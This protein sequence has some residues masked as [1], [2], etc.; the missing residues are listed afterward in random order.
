MSRRSGGRP[1]SR[2]VCRS[3]FGL[4][5]APILVVPVGHSQGLAPYL[6]RDI[7]QID[8][9]WSSSRPNAFL[10][11][12]EWLYFYASTTEAGQ[13]LW[14]TDGSR[15]GTGQVTD[16]CRGA[17][18]SV[19]QSWMVRVGDSLYFAADDGQHG[20]ELWRSD[21]TAG[22][23]TMVREIEPGLEGSYVFVLAEKRKVIFEHTRVE[24]RAHRDIVGD[25]ACVLVLEISSKPV[26][27]SSI[28]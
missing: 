11:A 13:E 24:R 19:Y 25:V 4:L 26:R 2:Q 8:A 28:S 7:N 17:C 27:R 10:V 20:V 3:A 14:R 12:D 18:D 16:L 21:G 9:S 5:L 22:G 6:V 15:S 23:T 1:T